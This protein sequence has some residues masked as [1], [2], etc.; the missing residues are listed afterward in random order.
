MKKQNIIQLTGKSWPFVYLKKT[1]MK[2]KIHVEG[3]SLE[4]HYY[5]I[6]LFIKLQKIKPMWLSG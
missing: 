2:L 3:R 5:Y 4:H 1:E 6:V